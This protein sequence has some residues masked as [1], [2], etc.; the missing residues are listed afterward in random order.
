MWEVQCAT[1]DKVS[2]FETL[3]EL[4]CECGNE[5]AFIFV[6]KSSD[7]G[8][9][10]EFAAAAHI[11]AIEETHAAMAAGIIKPRV[12]DEIVPTTNAES[13]LNLRYPRLLASFELR[14]RVTP[15]LADCVR[16]YHIL[17]IACETIQD[18]TFVRKLEKERRRAKKIMI[19]RKLQLLAFVTAKGDKSRPEFGSID[20]LRKGGVQVE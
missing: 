14:T 1:C 5:D 20:R 11:K 15:S 19:G 3:E 2:T 18:K 10:D 17:T 8:T 4:K 13:V 16:K 7:I 6:H 12:L 9:L